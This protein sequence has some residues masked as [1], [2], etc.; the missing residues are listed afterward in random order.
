MAVTPALVHS[1]YGEPASLTSRLYDPET[2]KLAPPGGLPYEGRGRCV[3]KGDTCD[4]YP[5]KDSEFCYAHNR[6]LRL[7]AAKKTEAED[8]AAAAVVAQVAED[9][10]VFVEHLKQVEVDAACALANAAEAVRAATA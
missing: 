10:R 9:H 2:S 7:A 4:A 1:L 6:A 8:A 5:E 3:A